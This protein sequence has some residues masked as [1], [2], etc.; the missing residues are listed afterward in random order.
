[1]TLTGVTVES[2]PRCKGKTT[3]PVSPQKDRE[4]EYGEKEANHRREHVSPVIYVQM[5]AHVSSTVSGEVAKWSRN[6][7]NFK[8]KNE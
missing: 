6:A 8:K 7:M 3:V 1:M 5:Q 4:T 2:V